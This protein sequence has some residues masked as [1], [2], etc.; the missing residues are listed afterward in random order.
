MSP[1]SLIIL[2]FN[3]NMLFYVEFGIK[4]KW[5]KTKA[6]YRSWSQRRT[7]CHKPDLKGR[8][9]IEGQSWKAIQ[10]NRMTRHQEIWATLDFKDSLLRGKSIWFELQKDKSLGWWQC[11]GKANRS[12]RI[13]QA[14]WQLRVDRITIAKQSARPWVSDWTILT[15]H[16][17]WRGSY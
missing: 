10:E 15:K 11:L 14:N 9:E 7:G 16:T 4:N 8:V 2:I 12:R 1:F 17:R 5:K 6:Q 13:V 3:E